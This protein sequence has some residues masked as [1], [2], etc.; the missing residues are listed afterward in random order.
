MDGRQDLKM[1]SPEF[2]ESDVRQSHPF[3][4]NGLHIPE[5]PS[6]GLP[7]GKGEPDDPLGNL[8]WFL[9]RPRE[10]FRAAQD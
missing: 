9:K 8:L 2:V 5:P 6:A 3:P 4:E 1:L 7:L 10:A